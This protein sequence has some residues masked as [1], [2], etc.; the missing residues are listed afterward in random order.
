MKLT[1]KSFLCLAL[2]ALA[3]SAQA[4][5]PAQL[6]EESLSPEQFN[7]VH[8]S[9][10]TPQKSQEAGALTE[11]LLKNQS[12]PRQEETAPAQRRNFVDDFIFGKLERDGIPH[13]PLASDTEF[14]RRATLDL[15]GRLPSPQEVRDFVDDEDSD[16]RGKLI[17]RLIDSEAW[18][19]KWAY[20]FM[21]LFRTNGKM[22]R[23]RY[24][25]HYWIK[26]NLRSDR[27]Y[28]DVVQQIITASAKSNHVVAAANLIAREHV[29][30][31]PQPRDGDD[32]S[33]VHQLDTHDELS[34]IYYKAFLGMNLSCISCHA[35]KGHLEEVNIWL[36]HKSRK[37]F[38]RNAAF[39]GR[40]RYLMYWE[41]GKP[42]S[43]EFLI[44]DHNPGYDTEGHSMI[45]VARPGGSNDPAFLLTNESPQ[46]EEEPRDALARMLTSHAQFPR[47]T[48]NMFWARLMGVGIVDPYDEFDLA[49]QDPD[50]LPEGWQL[51]PSHPKLLDAL[52][53][54]FEESGYRLKHLMKTICRSSAYQVSARFPGEWKES[55]T[56]YFARK[57]ARRLTA[58][59]LHDSIVLATERPAQ[60]EQAG[61]R[62]GLAMQLAGP[63]GDRDTKHFMRIFGQ[64]DRQTPAKL[65]AGSLQHPLVLMQSPVVNQR[66]LAEKDSRVQRLLDNY[67][68]DDSRV[69]EEMYLA[70]LSRWP[71]EREKKV[72]L[73]A[74]AKD[75]VNGA[76]DLQWALI[77]SVEFFFNY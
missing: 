13:A 69:V 3:M 51:Q 19:D 34:I 37:E 23:G 38:F 47:A 32:L 31:A 45:R 75:R 12:V 15:T 55:Y 1:G 48:V 43:G 53:K 28:N 54:D 42:Q 29:Q 49:R 61:K 46:P 6:R 2:V 21:D 41:N 5:E 33:M 58:E 67:P 60:F 72:A 65:A 39:L 74:L 17:E 50:N 73:A 63:A 35:G 66:V 11:Q 30:G 18:V 9:L 27:P 4:D 71:S 68:G 7:K 59:E 70:S 62:Y 64:S 77:N 24:L 44:D 8:K 10:F 26:E 36:S 14:L 40:T 56:R 52:A 57:F 22:G 25:F 20:F 16:K 76:Q